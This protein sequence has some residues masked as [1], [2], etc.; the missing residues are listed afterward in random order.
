MS[1]KEKKL[2]ERNKETFVKYKAEASLYTLTG[3]I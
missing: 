3:T 1:K 2:Y